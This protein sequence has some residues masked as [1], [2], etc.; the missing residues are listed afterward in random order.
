MTQEQFEDRLADIVAKIET[1]PEPQRSS[2]QQVVEQT[3][4]RHA[5]IADALNRARNALDDWRVMQKYLVF[6]A[7]CRRR[8][9]Q[10]DGE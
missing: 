10:A 6:D 2:L 4:S 7:E 5:E 1:L 9:E 8:E 3:R